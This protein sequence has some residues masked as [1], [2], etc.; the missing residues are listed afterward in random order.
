[1]TTKKRL[2]KLKIKITKTKDT[3]TL[4]LNKQIVIIN[5]KTHSVEFG[6]VSK[7]LKKRNGP[8]KIENSFEGYLLLRGVKSE[9]LETADYIGMVR[10]RNTKNFVPI[11]ILKKLK[12]LEKIDGDSMLSVLKFW[13]KL[14]EN[15]STNSRKQLYR[16]LIANN[17][18]ITTEGDIVME[19]GVSRNQDGVL[20]DQHTGKIDNSIGRI[21]SMPRKDVNDNPNE[22]CSRGLHAAPSDY[23][24]Q[25]Y[26]QDIIVKILV[27]PIDIVSVPT[28]YD[29]RKV[30]MCR[31]QVIGYS[32][33]TSSHLQGGTVIKLSDLIESDEVLSS[34][35]KKKAKQDVEKNVTE[36]DSKLLGNEYGFESMTGRKII[37]FIKEK[38]NIGITLNV[39]NKK[40]IVKKAYQI[41]NDKKIVEHF[42]ISEEKEEERVKIISL[43]RTGK[44]LIS[45]AKA[46]LN[47]NISR[48]EGKKANKGQLTEGFIRVF[49]KAGFKIVE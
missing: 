21:V 2:P 3:I 16:F 7:I 15:P 24:R 29:S 6:K 44:K 19:K 25:W 10:I 34:S 32:T 4:V 43:P 45:V 33:K 46:R 48:F 41:A 38:F 1:M 22:T 28:D 13:Y 8:R 23:V 14:D 40:G 49:E 47:E 12:E 9:V 31:Y 11:D 17:I 18:P 26:S 37:N 20:V 36:T 5:S 30:R 27:N 35:A 39:K 42:Q